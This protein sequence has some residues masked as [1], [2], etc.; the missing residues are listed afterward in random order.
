MMCSTWGSHKEEYQQED[1][2]IDGETRHH[3]HE[4]LVVVAADS[5]CGQIP[6]VA[7][8][9]TGLIGLNNNM[10]KCRN[11][12]YR[13]GS[14]EQRFSWFL[15]VNCSSSSYISMISYDNAALSLG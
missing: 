10:V 6:T 1:T 14:K 4:Y 13:V 9:A 12:L 2:S 5:W 3:L 8:V 15:L 11:C 7:L